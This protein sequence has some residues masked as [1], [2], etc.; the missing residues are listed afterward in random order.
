[1]YIVGKLVT[2]TTAS[3]VRKYSKKWISEKNA[4]HLKCCGPDTNRI[5]EI[6]LTY[7]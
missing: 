5:P 7:F 1:M 2:S 4:C 3:E 6:I